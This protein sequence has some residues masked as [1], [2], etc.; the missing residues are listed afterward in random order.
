ML[1]DLRIHRGVDKETLS[2]RP[3]QKSKVEFSEMADH[4]AEDR[5]YA[6]QPGKAQ[7]QT[8]PYDPSA[9]SC[10]DGRVSVSIALKTVFIKLRDSQAT[11]H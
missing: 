7:D 3:S 9:Y 1:K 8:H 6:I 10:K 5:N 4:P 11:R 2:A